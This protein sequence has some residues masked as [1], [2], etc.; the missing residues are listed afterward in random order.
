MHSSQ[1]SPWWSIAN[2]L[3]FGEI[4]IRRLPVYTTVAVIAIHS[5]LRGPALG[6]VL[7]QEVGD[8]LKAGVVIDG[9]INQ[10]AAPGIGRE[11]A[12]RDVLD[13]AHAVVVVA[14]SDCA[15]S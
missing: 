1:P 13:T 5:T 8:R 2:A 6:G 14:A 7:T 4:H 3:Y 11:F 12:S 15:D 9:A 10:L